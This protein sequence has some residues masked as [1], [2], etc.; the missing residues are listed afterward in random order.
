MGRRAQE[1]ASIEGLRRLR[2][3]GCDEIATV[4]RPSWVVTDESISRM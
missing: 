2:V 3:E 1:C 4:D